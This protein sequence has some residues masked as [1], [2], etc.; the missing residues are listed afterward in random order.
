MARNNASETSIDADRKVMIHALSA[1]TPRISGGVLLAACLP[2]LTLLG[3]WS[4]NRF[5]LLG[6]MLSIAVV[7]LITISSERLVPTNSYPIVI[8]VLALTLTLVSVVS[9]PRDCQ[10]AGLKVGR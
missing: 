8:F 6:V 9:V 1:D 5:V 4:H 3:A 7:V 2:T 10:T